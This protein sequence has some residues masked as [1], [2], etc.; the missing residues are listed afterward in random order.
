L[1]ISAD[2]LD[3]PLRTVRNKKKRNSLEIISQM[4]EAAGN[5]SR[6]TGI[7]YRA[8]LS[9]ALLV[10]YLSILREKEFLET[11]DNT[12]F[13]PTRKGNRF[14]KEF[15]EFRELYESYEEKAQVIRKLFTR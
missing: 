13:F 5:G 3:R 15:R 8:N 6:K 12:I 14:V 11:S 1:S 4:L 2:A 10:Q 7:M 9:Y